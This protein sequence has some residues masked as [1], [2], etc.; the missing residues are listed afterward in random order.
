MHTSA[1]ATFIAAV[2]WVT[3]A[4]LGCLTGCADDASNTNATAADTS[5]VSDT[6]STSGD[7]TSGS[8]EDTSGATADATT[9][10]DTV[11]ADIDENRP[12]D[13]DSDGIL[14]PDEGPPDIDTDSD[15]TPD[16]LDTDSDNDGI[17]DVYE[18][19]DFDPFT[20]PVDSDGDGVP[21]FRDLDSNNNGVPDADER[22]GDINDNGVPDYLEDDADGDAL[23]DLL[24][25][26]GGSADCDG[27]DVADAPGTPLAPRDCD[28][29]GIPDY[30]EPDSDN[31]GIPDLFEGRTTDTDGDGW[32]DRYDLDSD[33]DGIPDRDEHD[34][35]SATLRDTDG[36]TIPDFR[37]P[38]ADGDGLSDRDEAATYGTDPFNADSD[39]DG[40]TDLIEVAAGTNPN[41]TD[42]N[43]L[44]NGD[45]IFVLPYEAPPSPVLDTLTFRTNFQQADVFFLI[46]RTGSMLAEIT[47]MKYAITGI[48]TSLSC[49]RS[50]A[51]CADDGDCAPSE[52]CDRA[53]GLCI[54]DPA[55]TGCIPSFW[56]G[57]GVYG[58]DPNLNVIA[59]LQSIN[60]D[61]AA[62]AAALPDEVGNYGTGEAMFAAIQCLLTPGASGCAPAWTSGCV[63]GSV[64]AS[65]C[66][67]YRPDAA[68]LF[69][70]IS[71]E[72]NQWTNPAFTAATA[73]QALLNS[74]VTVI[75]ID[76]AAG[77]A[78]NGAADLTAVASLSESVDSTGQ[79]LLRA[80]DGAT[81]IREVTAAIGE[82]INNVPITVTIE[83]LEVDGDA[84]DALRFLDHLEAN[85]SGDDLNSDG[86]IDCE[87]QGITAADG[88]DLDAF[89]D[90][91][92][93]LK[94][95]RRICWDVHP[96][97]NTV[98]PAGD[99]VKLYRLQLV[100]RGNG[101]ILDQRSVF[102]LIP[103]KPPQ[104]IN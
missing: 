82:V 61:G 41:R 71:D 52:S 46:D 49:A 66:V 5:S 85:L 53:E 50:V 69:V 33:N 7:G 22:R 90:T 99:Q 70:I 88:P 55:Q 40:V 32:L 63:P 60:P 30:L 38:D 18:A 19:G 79:P 28:A 10:A 14:D 83:P 64:G 37:D 9:S 17:P 81:I 54:E 12:K 95:G 21:D 104:I 87:S 72:P 26:E 35:A 16:Y 68:R 23:S 77:G 47:A 62:T 98:E 96:V 59:N 15:G 58:G 27:D 80:G 97:T 1:K 94:P 48:I 91:F 76:A 101:A 29:D 51:P 74:Q 36:D 89:L 34:P 78:G 13:A 102:F 84:G 4:L 39:G 2:A 20:S 92:P 93:A 43:P 67:G 44:R 57:S 6:A 73:A 25:I 3:C 45:F 100:V 11:R 103:P 75:G 56:T 31:D 65:D 86:V 8:A 42:D 24:E